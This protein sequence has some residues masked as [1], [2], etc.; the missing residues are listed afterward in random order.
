MM[1]DKLQLKVNVAKEDFYLEQNE[2]VKSETEFNDSNDND[3]IKKSSIKLSKFTKNT[4]SP[5]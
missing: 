2:D 1:K 5:L 3:L 4:Q